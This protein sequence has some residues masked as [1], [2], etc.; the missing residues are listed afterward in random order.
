[1]TGRVEDASGISELTVNGR[2]PIL[3]AKGNFSIHL[4]LQLGRNEILI[5]AKNVH[6]NVSRKR[7][8]LEAT[9]QG[10]AE[11]A[12]LETRMIFSDQPGKYHALI[13]GNNKYEHLPELHT[14]INDATEID[15][16]LR[17]KYGFTT[18]LLV[19][20]GRSQI[21]NSLNEVRG[22][23]GPEDNLII[24]YA[25]HGEFDKTVGKAY[26]LPID[27]QP[28]NDTNWIIVDNITSNIKRMSSRH[29][30]VVADSCYSGTLTRSAPTK[31]DTTRDKKRF[32]EKMK[33]RPSRTLIASREVW[34]H[35]HPAG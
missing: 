14:A 2:S 18:T 23:L 32:I 31:L 15:R 13:I 12:S 22:R 35:H 21:M 24:Y 30:L 11:T 28:D 26:W 7:F 33:Q 4:P 6:Q 25:G 19:D 16:L 20:A 1:M 8:W 10:N 3:D 29:I 34:V 9:R 27:A 5:V 17:E